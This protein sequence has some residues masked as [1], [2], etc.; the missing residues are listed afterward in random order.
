MN[1]AASVINFSLKEIL[2]FMKKFYLLSEDKLEKII[3]KRIDEAFA[4]TAKNYEQELLMKQADISMLQEQINPHFLYNALECIRAQA[5]LDDCPDIARATHALSLFFRY[6]IS[7][8]S[9]FVPLKE[10]LENVR[11]YVTIQQYRF[12]NRFS[13]VIQ[14]DDEAA[15]SDALVPKLMLQPIV[16]NSILHGFRNITEGGRITVHLFQTER[17]IH[18]TVSD[19]GEGMDTETLHLLSE[20]LFSP[21][22]HYAP[23]KER[24]FG[25]ALGNVNKRIRLFFGS[26]YGLSLYSTKGIGT[27]VELIFPLR[28][29][30][31]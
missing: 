22:N 8:R 10:E 1:T 20:V 15:I 3:Q 12:K 14:N 21:E 2:Y 26:E 28:F 24:R 16:E 18:I 25:I 6:S 7:T 19:N 30:S 31:K 23:Q 11:N 13:L 9:A 27:D 29:S 5:L 4:S 17:H